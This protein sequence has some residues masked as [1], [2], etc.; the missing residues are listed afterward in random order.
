MIGQ[1]ETIRCR[2]AFIPNFSHC[3]VEQLQSESS[4]SLQFL[5][6]AAVMIT[7]TVMTL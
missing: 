2:A 5:S 1:N 7:F 6:S 4:P 3:F